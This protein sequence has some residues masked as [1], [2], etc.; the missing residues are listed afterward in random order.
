MNPH[1]CR[2]IIQRGPARHHPKILIKS[3]FSRPDP[4][5]PIP[6]HLSEQYITCSQSRA[7][8]L[9]QTKG[10]AQQAQIFCGRSAFLTPRGIFFPS[11]HP[12]LT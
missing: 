10:R 9:R 12:A 4:G 5:R 11:E 6:R 3:Y 1:Q 2:N 7:H 8:F